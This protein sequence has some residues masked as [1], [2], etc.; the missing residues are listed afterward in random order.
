MELPRVPKWNEDCMVKEVKIPYVAMVWLASFNGLPF[1][2]CGF[3]KNFFIALWCTANEVLIRPC[4]FMKISFYDHCLQCIY[5]LLFRKLF[6][7]FYM[8]SC[9]FLPGLTSSFGGIILERKSRRGLLALY[10][11]NVVSCFAIFLVLENC[12]DFA[13]KW[14]FLEIRIFANNGFVL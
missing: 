8:L 7:R 6:G 2:S 4:T 14:D 11:L 1:V 10:M 3:I 5:Q 12:F 13:E 9:G